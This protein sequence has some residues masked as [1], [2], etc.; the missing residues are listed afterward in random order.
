MWNYILAFEAWFWQY[1][2]ILLLILGLFFTLISRGMQFKLLGNP[3]HM[4]TFVKDKSLLNHEDSASVHP[5]KLL[6]SSVGG[7]VGLGNIVLVMLSVTIGGPGAVFWLW[8]AAILCMP[9]KYAEIFLGIKYRKKTKEG[10]WQGGPMFFLQHAFSFKCLPIISAFLLCIYGIEVSQFLIIS[11][12]ISQ[13]L[14][15]NKVFVVGFLLAITLYASLGGVDRLSKICSTLMPVFII[16]YLFIGIYILIIY[17]HN[18]LNSIGL[19]LKDALTGSAALGGFAGSTMLLAA[20]QGTQRAV[21]SGDLAIGYDATIQSESKVIDPT[22][23][24]RLSI[25]G[26]FLDAFVCTI[27][28]LMLLVTNLWQQKLDQPLDYVVKLMSDNI[29]YGQHFLTI[30]IFLAGFTT[31]IAYFTVAIKCGNFISPKYGKRAV[32]IYAIFAFPF[33]SYYDQTDAVAF[34]SICQAMLVIINSLAM[35]KLYR[36][37]NFTTK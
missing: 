2:F 34:M 23:Q 36:E 5:L 1:A 7:M 10:T 4:F 28:V 29:W 32:I 22:T 31:I 19:I 27:S 12:Q 26:V 8:I 3:K 20:Q 15:L 17:R 13:S 6:F 35:F 9:V 24:A 18:F 21:Y 11:D 33:F 16:L 30:L 25:F 14:N 37:I